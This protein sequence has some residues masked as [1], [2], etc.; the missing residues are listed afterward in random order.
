MQTEKFL[1]QKNGSK[2]ELPNQKMLFR[3][4]SRL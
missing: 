2:G 3:L 4:A 1:M